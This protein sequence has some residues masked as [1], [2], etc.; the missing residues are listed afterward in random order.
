MTYCY[1]TGCKNGEPFCPCIM[2]EKGIIQ[3]NGRWVRPE[4][5]CGPVKEPFRRDTPAFDLSNKCNKCGMVFK[6][7]MGYVCHDPE[8]PMG[9]GPTIV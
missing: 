4:K 9:A 7:I 3:R 5:D 1:C 8:C 2:K 6:G